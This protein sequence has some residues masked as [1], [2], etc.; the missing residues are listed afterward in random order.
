MELETRT[1]HIDALPQSITLKKYTLKVTAGGNKGLER[2]FDRRAVTVGTSDECNFVLDDQTVSRS[3]SRIEFDINGYRIEDL[4]SKNGTFVNG[5]RIGSA[6]LPNDS[7]IKLGQTEISFK[8]KDDTVKIEISQDARFGG[9]LGVS[10][11]MREIF[12]LLNRVAPTDATVLIEGESG[13]GKELAAEAVH[14]ASPRGAK[15]FVIFDCSAVPK[16]LLESE[17]FG[18]VKG[19]FTGAVKD[20]K[21]AFEE[22]HNGTLFIDEIGELSPELQPKLLRALEK[23]EIKHVGSNER[24]NVDCRI[25]AA[26]NRK[27]ESEV[28]AGNFRED[29][30]YRLAVI[31]VEI[32]PLRKR[33]EDIPFLINNFLDEFAARNDGRRF[34]IS[35]ETMEKLKNYPWPG[36]VRELKN[37]IERSVIL[38]DSENIGQFLAGDIAPIRE[39]PGESGA[40]FRYDLPFKDAKER[41]MKDF[42]VRYFERMLE[43]TGGNISKAAKLSGIHRKSLE[44]I[45]KRIEVGKR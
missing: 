30:Y 44:Y 37:F 13:T 20:R 36:N 23:K 1:I 3:H 6:Y 12:A 17:L 41:L 21:G 19:A 35:Y 7:A 11:A 18:H 34:R 31:K 8:L 22:A 4:G 45:L 43:Q 29:L 14:A 38:S 10:I 25:V 39:T 15:P 24:I 28:R 2:I 33:I 40:V 5:I 9:L 26:T 42:E 27:I 16:D 32:P